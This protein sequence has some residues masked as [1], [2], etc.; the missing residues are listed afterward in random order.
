M[1]VHAASRATESC[2]PTRPTAPAIDCVHC[3]SL[4]SRSPAVDA[5]LSSWAAPFL[6]SDSKTDTRF[7]NRATFCCS[8]ASKAA[9]SVAAMR[10]NALDV[11]REAVISISKPST[12]GF[13]CFAGSSILTASF[14]TVDVMP[15]ALATFSRNK[16]RKYQYFTLIQGRQPL[17]GFCCQ[18]NACSMVGRIRLLPHILQQVPHVADA[19]RTCRC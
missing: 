12:H 18:R 13:S 10:S 19:I 8:A 5:T 3:R 11:R 16:S 6:C 2:S 14:H 9:L 17:H 4:A 1:R 7:S 15:F